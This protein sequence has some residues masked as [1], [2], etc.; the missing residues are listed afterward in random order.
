MSEFQAS[1]DEHS[2]TMKIRNLLI[3]PEFVQLNSFHSFIYI[4]V[5]TVQ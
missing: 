4:E 5:H 1:K 3:H 2:Y